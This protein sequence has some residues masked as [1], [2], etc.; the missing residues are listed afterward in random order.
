MGILPWFVSR[1]HRSSLRMLRS[2]STSTFVVLRELPVL[3]L[4][5]FCVD[6]TASPFGTP[7]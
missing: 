4:S 5:F 2:A 7:V 1:S 6:G 3:L